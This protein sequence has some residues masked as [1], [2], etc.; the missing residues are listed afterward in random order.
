MR[1]IRI[2]AP[3][4]PGSHSSLFMIVSGIIVQ[5]SSRGNDAIKER[6]VASIRVADAEIWK[7]ERN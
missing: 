5:R 4:W 7:A 2:V 1:S 3:S 6:R